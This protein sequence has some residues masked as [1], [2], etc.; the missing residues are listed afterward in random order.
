MSILLTWLGWTDTPPL[1]WC[2]PGTSVLRDHEFGGLD[3]ADKCVPRSDPGM[4]TP[5]LS[6]ALEL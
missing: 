2:T 1:P 4:A 6:F 3:P 5:S